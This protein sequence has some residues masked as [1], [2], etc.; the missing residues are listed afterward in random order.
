MNYLFSGSFGLSEEPTLPTQ[1]PA[2]DGNP[3]PSPAGVLYSTLLQ[4]RTH[5]ETAKLERTTLKQQI[6]RLQSDFALLQ[7]H[8][9]SLDQPPTNKSSFVTLENKIKVL[10]KRLSTETCR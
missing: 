2:I 1:A 10:Q 6:H 9:E 8:I 3:T 5:A 4:L 7:P